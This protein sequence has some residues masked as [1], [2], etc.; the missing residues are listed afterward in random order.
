MIDV[1]G[2]HDSRQS[3]AAVEKLSAGLS[4]LSDVYVVSTL[5]LPAKL[6]GV[7]LGLYSKQDNRKYLELAVMGKINKGHS[8]CFDSNVSQRQNSS[9]CM[10]TVKRIDTVRKEGRQEKQRRG[11]MKERKEVEALCGALYRNPS[12]T[13]VFWLVR[14]PSSSPFFS[15]HSPG[16]LRPSR[17]EAP[18]GQPAERQPGRRADSLHH[19]EARRS[20]PRQHEHGAVRQLP[21]SRFQPGS[22]AIGPSAQGGG[23]GG[24]KTR[25]EGVRPT[26]GQRRGFCQE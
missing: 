10:T 7:L 4:A 23:V 13:R 9:V 24:D 22:T 20:S 8:K 2:L 14:T 16:S 25:T 17:W 3:A 18:H 19:P 15:S 26:T 5:R 21:I 12:I 1:L 11:G 6:G